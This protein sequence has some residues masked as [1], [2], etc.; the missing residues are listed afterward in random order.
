EVADA[1]E[2]AHS[3]GI[4]HRDIKPANIMLNGRG[5]VKVLDFGLA[6]R[7]AQDE[8]S[9][10][11]TTGSHTR[12]GMLIGTPHYMSPEQVLGRDLDPRSTASFSNAWKRTRS[13]ATA[14][15]KPWPATWRS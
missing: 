2:T 7:F 13:N 14:P 9:T 4:V 12:S 15:P 8:L 10:S 1:L 3:R 11:T 5:Q 6:K